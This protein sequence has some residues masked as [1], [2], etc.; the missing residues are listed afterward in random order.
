MQ[1]GTRRMVVGFDHDGL[2]DRHTGGPD[3]R[4]GDRVGD[5]RVAHQ[6]RSGP[7]R[8]PVVGDLAKGD[9]EGVDA[10]LG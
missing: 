2:A 8:V 3:L 4:S 5:Y 7:Q 10:A 1:V 9:S 6:D